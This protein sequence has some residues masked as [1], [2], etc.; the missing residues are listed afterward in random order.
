M[1]ARPLIT[2][3]LLIAL[4]ICSTVLLTASPVQ[5]EDYTPYC[6]DDWDNDADGRTDY[7]DD[8]GCTDSSDDSEYDDHYRDRYD[9][10]DRYDRYDSY[11][12]YDSYDYYHY[13]ITSCNDNRDNDGDGFYDYPDDPGCSSY[14][15]S[16]EMGT[17]DRRYDFEYRYDRSY[18]YDR[19]ACEDGRDNDGDGYYDYPDDPGCRSRSDVSEMG[20][21]ERIY[22]RS[23][24]SDRYDYSYD[25]YGRSACEDGRDNDGDGDY[26]YPDDRGCRSRSDESE[27]DAGDSRYDRY[28]AYYDEDSFRGGLVTLEKTASRFEAAPGDSVSYT[29]FLR[30]DRNRPVED[31]VVEDVWP[32]GSADVINTG[33]AR[34]SGTGLTWHIG[35]MGANTTRSLTYS[36]RIDAS[37]AAGRKIRNIA[38]ARGSFGNVTASSVLQTTRRRN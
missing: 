15:D 29:L 6:R 23:Y 31:V 34:A 36:V 9:V 16:S 30:N 25:R 4:G 35:R 27:R 14:E 10:Y 38:T 17:Y 28:D 12:R 3:G 8:P 1:R 11:R 33:E 5:A 2:T 32:S 24:T 21:N 22:D 7:P 19:Y 37:V 13:D 18:T 20:S 26:D